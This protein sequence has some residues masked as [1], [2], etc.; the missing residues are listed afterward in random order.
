MSTNP[1]NSNT[2]APVKPPPMPDYSYCN[3][4]PFFAVDGRVL[5]S[6]PYFSQM[7][8]VPVGFSYSPYMQAPEGD[9]GL[10]A[11]GS[12]RTIPIASQ[13]QPSYPV[14]LS[15]RNVLDPAYPAYYSPVMQSPIQGPAFH[16]MSPLISKPLAM[17]PI[18]FMSSPFPNYV[19][20]APTQPSCP[21]GEQKNVAG[22]SLPKE[23]K[24][25]I[26]TEPKRENQVEEK[27]LNPTLPDTTAKLL[28]AAIESDTLSDLH[29]KEFL[30][31][32]PFEGSISPPF[33]S[34]SR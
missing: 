15:S 4:I 18:Y 3:M 19:M 21:P 29:T 13:I 9:H 22:A 7:S 1:H 5:S 33:Q 11:V 6:T 16:I 8:P 34:I 10:P 26:K 28:P 24:E 14:P 2:E 30:E 23:E 25:A 17:D 27:P 32:S 20:F 31:V 12:M